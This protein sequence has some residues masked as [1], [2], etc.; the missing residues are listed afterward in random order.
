M[1]ARTPP[2]GPYRAAQIA[3][4]NRAG[5]LSDQAAHDMVAAIDRYADRLTKR[6][7]ALPAGTDAARKKALEAAIKI[8]KDAHTELTASLT[9]AIAQKRSLAFTDIT[10][11]WE[12]ASKSAA[13]TAGVADALLGA[14]QLP[15][16]TMAG[17][18]EGLGGVPYFRSLTATGKAAGSEVATILRDG[19]TSGVRPDEIARRLRPYVTGAE[20]FEKAFPKSDERLAA[21]HKSRAKLP[22]ELKG[23]AG[24]IRSNSLRIAY[25]EIHNA[26]AE[27]ELQA[28][29]LDPLVECVRWELSPFRGSQAE[30]DPCDVYAHSNF[31]GLGP[32]K[33]PLDAVPLPPHPR[34]RCER[35]PVTRAPEDWHKPKPSGLKR[36][37]KAKDASLGPN[38]GKL[39]A[40]AAGRVRDVVA[41]QLRQL[42]QLGTPAQMQKLM[43]FGEKAAGELLE[44][45]A[46]RQSLLAEMAKIAA[47]TAVEAISAAA[48]PFKIG[49][50]T[51][52]TKLEGKA[53]EDAKLLVN[54]AVNNR[55]TAAMKALKELGADTTEAEA[56]VAKQI[57]NVK[58]KAAAKKAAAKVEIPTIAP[59]PTTKAAAMLT[60]TPQEIEWA[61]A[62][63]ASL[64]AKGINISAAEL[65]VN[66]KKL[67]GAIVDTVMGD[68]AEKK[69]ALA[70][71]EAV[72]A[73]VSQAKAMLT[74]AAPP[75][76]VIVPPAP[77]AA[78]ASIAAI[79]NLQQEL[80]DSGVFLLTKK[81][82]GDNYDD[83]KAALA[84][85]TNA[86]G[87]ND[88]IAAIAVQKLKALGAKTDALEKKLGLA[89]VQPPASKIPAPA[90]KAPPVVAPPPAKFVENSGE[91][92]L[93]KKVGDQAGSNKGGFYV[94]QDG[95][96]RYVKVYDEAS[97][98][99]GEHLANYIY[100]ALGLGAPD[101]TTFMYNGKLHYASRIIEGA[102]DATIK[103]LGLTADRAR[104][105]LD[106]FAA[107][108][109][110]GNWDA[111]GLGLD[112]M[113]DVGGKVIRIDNGSAF[114]F[115]AQGGHKPFD[116][117]FKIS[118]W[119]GFA[120]GAKNLNPDYAN[121][122]K[123]AGYSSPEDMGA[124]LVKQIDKILD[125]EANNLGWANL[126]DDLVPGMSS[127]DRTLVAD[128]LD[129]R[130]KLLKAK[131][132]A[133][134]ASLTKHVPAP[135]PITAP[136]AAAAK[137]YGLD[138]A[139]IATKLK[140]QTKVG[141][142]KTATQ[143][144]VYIT[145]GN[146]KSGDLPYLKQLLTSA[147]S[148]DAQA[149]KALKNPLA[150]GA[151]VTGL[152]KKLGL[153]AATVTAPKPAPL[154]GFS[155][156]AAVPHVP[157]TTLIKPAEVA[158][159]HAASEIKQPLYWQGGNTSMAGLKSTGVD[160]A[161]LPAGQVGFE[162]ETAMVPLKPTSKGYVEIAIVSK[163]PLKVGGSSEAFLEANLKAKVP[164]W[165]KAAT[166]AAKRQLLLDNGY[167]ALIIT[168]GSGKVT[169]VVA[170]KPDIVK[171]V[172]KALTPP[173]APGSTHYSHHSAGTTA[174]GTYSGKAPHELPSYNDHNPPPK[175]AG[176]IA[177]AQSDHGDRAASKALDKSY[178][179][180]RTRLTN[181]EAYAVEEYTGSAYAAING[182]LRRNEKLSYAGLN[183]IRKNLGTA[184]R[185]LR[186]T[187]D[188]VLYRG[189]GADHPYVQ[190]LRNK[191]Y[192]GLL[193]L[194]DEVQHDL[195]FMSTTTRMQIARRFATS[196]RVY[197]EVRAPKGTP[198]FWAKLHGGFKGE[199]GEHEFLLS[200]KQEYRILEVREENPSDTDHP[201]IR[202]IVELIL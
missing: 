176:Y 171:V 63:Q 156:P 24:R 114:L 123:T 90:P 6:L 141:V 87:P 19:I 182:A 72:G 73:D 166:A 84:I 113:V 108:I 148:G 70:A 86:K 118:E 78:K 60:A 59:A 109:L 136:P 125:L 106:G 67:A 47:S 71:F 53:L 159:V 196:E 16:F 168:D 13:T 14:V 116:Q 119:E 37:L 48:A 128:M 20:A 51:F 158:G 96:K 25:S 41:G 77:T 100:E 188:L 169:K 184:V 144:G 154:P 127:A 57:A 201:K 120:P 9:A 190:I 15:N 115:R 186:T 192:A 75:P 27:A 117:L 155:G 150:F 7:A 65:L 153:Q 162:L 4:R 183:D 178:A 185:K 32:G 40:E 23:A 56:Y 80:K 137:A 163:K 145:P 191:G 82:I 12:S 92:I 99:H 103:K 61:Q 193:E 142:Q 157:P 46:A 54:K 30:P 1:P 130:T 143:M 160:M 151:D 29:A 167:D 10:K 26:R 66:K 88:K 129:A 76:P 181:E 101:S 91:N 131:R 177:N 93:Y 200:E 17:A 102:E 64:S 11:V 198:G 55:S 21:M 18:F 152:E 33:Y 179:N 68:A 202:I 189:L 38:I 107:D 133:I 36:T 138:P 94:G 74:A 197:L 174:Q 124:A 45:A 147:A 172:D 31:Y 199:N 22:P 110:T 140:K 139:A 3:A 83:I 50:V 42:E 28:Y 146:I 35:V 5:A 98:A 97:Q 52:P 165:D 161:K 121:L 79:E 69:A 62:A 34:D 58:A 126:V 43:Q 89:V 122:F 170:L 164:G 134:A 194:V 180:W 81:Q 135:A 111:P 8:A 132:D 39:T 112:N 44:I 104:K 95:V 2:P 149:I 105:A 187:D 49:K 173:V 175:P 195:G 85:A